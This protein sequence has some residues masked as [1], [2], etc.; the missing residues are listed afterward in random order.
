MKPE[1]HVWIHLPN[2]DKFE[3]DRS[4]STFS[5]L[6]EDDMSEIRNLFASTSDIE[7]RKSVV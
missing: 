2:G 6:N 5:P 3:M 7:N 4:K 1:T